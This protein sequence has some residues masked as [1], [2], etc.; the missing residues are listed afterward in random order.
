MEPAEQNTA[1][2]PLEVGGGRAEGDAPTG[3]LGRRWGILW[4]KLSE[5]LKSSSAPLYN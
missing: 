1:G 2:N 5:L 4:D 3:R